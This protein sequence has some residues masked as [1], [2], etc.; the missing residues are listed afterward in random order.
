[1][2][3]HEG[4]VE[5]DRDL[6][7]RLAQRVL[8]GG[9]HDRGQAARELDLL[10]RQETGVA[11]ARS[12]AAYA[13]TIVEAGEPVLLAGWHREVYRIWNEALADLRPVMFTGTESVPAKNKAKA[14]FIEGR[15]DLMIMSLRSGSG[16]DGLQARCANVVHGEFDW[17]P[18]VHAQ[19]NGRPRRYGQLRPVTAH[20]LHV[21]GGSDPVLMETLGLKAS[22]SHWILNPY[23]GDEGA[24]PT[25]ETRIK[26]L[27]RA[28]LERGGA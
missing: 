28:V 24:T 3:W 4:D 16:L 27:A 1:M 22:Q 8:S 13:R 11:K 15:S 12:V 9:W 6:Q 26:Q 21:D 17:S 7:R 23:G 19:V 20:Y 10:L 5:T 2:G 14:D 25:D 18:Q